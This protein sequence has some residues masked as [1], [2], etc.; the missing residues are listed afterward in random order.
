MKILVASDIHGSSYFT[1]KL[2]KII[3]KQNFD[4]IILLGDIYY[5]GPRNKFPKGYNPMK[6]AELLNQF[7]SKIRCVKG[8]CD[9][10]VDQMISKFEFEFSIEM[11]FAHKKF[12]F[13]HGHR[14]NME[15]LP[16][17]YS[18]I[19]GGHTHVSGIQKIGTTFYVNPG[20]LSLPKSNTK[21]S[22]VVLD[23]TSVSLFE[24]NGNL[25]DRKNFATKE[26][27]TK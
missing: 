17:G 16:K 18:F 27:I 14:L 7:S 23:E 19:F 1:K 11:T 3:E 20:S 26:T 8:N 22:Y 5:H 4:K 6:V 24:L 13:T 21:N 10:E 2:V 25:I 15:A 12:L 9:S